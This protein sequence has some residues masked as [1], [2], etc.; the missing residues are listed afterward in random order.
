[1]YGKKKKKTRERERERET[2]SL[3]HY[4][5]LESL[6]FFGCPNQWV[7][8]CIINRKIRK[9][10]FFWLQKVDSP[11]I[12]LH[13]SW[14]RIKKNHQK[15]PFPELFFL[16]LEPLPSRLKPPSL[17]DNHTTIHYGYIILDYDY[18]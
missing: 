11:Q 18:I 17:S 1:M 10:F 8:A 6:F 9:P 2:L 14:L 3:Y 4:L 5:S 13:V 7:E 12:Y 16:P 15:P